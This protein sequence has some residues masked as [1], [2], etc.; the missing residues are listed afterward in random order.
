MR[1]DAINTGPPLTSKTLVAYRAEHG[2]DFPESLVDQLIDQNGGAPRAD[3]RVRVGNREE[4]VFSFF[5]VNMPDLATE[6]SWNAAAFRR[7]VPSGTLP[8][9]NDPA[10][11]LFL[12]DS[13]LA[14]DGQVWFWDHEREGHADAATLVAPSLAEFLALLDGVE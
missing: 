2:L 10:G 8:I 7:R 12:I 14:P 6:L 1:F 3:V 9:G 5:G 13:V 11:N 4:E